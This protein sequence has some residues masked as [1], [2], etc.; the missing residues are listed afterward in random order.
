MLFFY[1]NMVL[2]IILFLISTFIELLIF[3]IMHLLK[4]YYMYL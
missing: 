2:H 1:G 3:H 4:Y